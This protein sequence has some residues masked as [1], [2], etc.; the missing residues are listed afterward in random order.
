MPGK[1]RE[2]EM[3]SDTNIY[4]PLHVQT[5]FL[6]P[7]RL[8]KTTTTTQ[9]QNPKGV[10]GFGSWLDQIHGC[11][12]FPSAC[13]LTCSSAPGGAGQPFGVG[14]SREAQVPESQSLSTWTGPGLKRLGL[15][16]S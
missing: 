16:A 1:K 7:W 9:K 3:V 8:V 6:F 12:Q 10:L 14:R 13:L 2:L 11:H 5:A 15:D 4:W